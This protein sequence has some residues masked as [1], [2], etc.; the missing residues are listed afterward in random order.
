MVEIV[1]TQPERT[2]LPLVVMPVV[3][4]SMIEPFKR[5]FGLLENIARVRMYEDFTLD[6][7]TI[8]ARCD[9]ADAVM[10]IGFHCTDS[11][12]ERTHAKCYAFGG[13]GVASYINL[14]KAKAQGIRV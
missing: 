2:D 3:V 6:E 10:V 14:E 12:L 13:T 7:D 11:I 5:C 8:V 4:A 9:G 1:E